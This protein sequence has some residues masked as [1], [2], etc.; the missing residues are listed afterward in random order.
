[1]ALE[2]IYIMYMNYWRHGLPAGTEP[3][4]HAGGYGTVRAQLQR[5]RSR[6]APGESSLAVVVRR[7]LLMLALLSPLAAAESGGADVVPLEPVVV[8]SSRSL[9]PV[10]EVV[11]MVTVLDHTDID[12]R[13]ATSADGLWRYTPGIQVESAGARFPARSLRIRGVGGNRV[14]MEVDGIPTQQSLAVGSFGYAARNGAE[15]DFIRRIEVLRGPASSLY[16]S[17]AIGGVVAVST[18]DPA[19]FP[20]LPGDSGGLLKGAYSGDRDSLGASAIGA[21]QGESTGWLLAGSSRRG[22]EADLSADPP[23][24]DRLDRDRAAILAKL[25][26]AD[27]ADRRLRLTLDADR[28]EAD[29]ALNSLVGQSRFANT[30]ALTGDDRETGV[31]LALDGH[32]DWGALRLHGAL[33]HR[34]TR[35]RQDTLDVRGAL[36]S[37]V[38]IEREFRFDTTTS[39]ARGRITRELETGRLRHRM[40]LGI[41]YSRRELEQSRDALQTDLASGDSSNIV[42][43]EK[44]PLRDFPVTVIHESGIFLQDEID[45]MPGS[46][47]VIPSVRFDRSRITV[48]DDA[49]WRA[50]NPDAMLAE[51]TVSDTS[52]RLGVLWRPS[53]AFQAWGQ[54]ATGFRAPPAEDLNIGLDIPLFGVR[55]LPNPAL[56]SETSVGWE[57]GVRGNVRGAWYSVAGFWTDYDDFIVSLV[58]LGPDPESGTLLFQSQNLER[59]RI[60]GSELEAGMPLGLLSGRLK[61]F[62]AGFSG[63]WAE[64]ENRGQGREFNEA[65][66]LSAALHLDWL[67]EA[68]V[69]ELRLSGTFSRG[70]SGGE[71][72]GM[73]LF[74]VPGYGVI[75]LA[76]A[77]HVNPRLTLRAGLFNLSDK[78]WWRAS[79]VPQ[80]PADD[81]LI[82][83]F[84]APGRSASVSFN[85]G[86]GP[87][88][89]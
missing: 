25:V 14:A 16:G 36:G 87:G 39:G 55:A 1:M 27:D 47:T 67:S 70:R 77:W 78:T 19:D 57:L 13:M 79:D 66:A 28:E 51:Q 32:T 11:G 10:S 89:G 9:R 69:L 7:A 44:F 30:T 48:R 65:D 40:M 20:L 35:T 3:A 41:E 49:L 85:L 61:G 80:L 38:E 15:L 83:S 56:D 43:G 76:A 34:N 73:P 4:A 58:P 75:D 21:W 84:S 50:A 5:P 12:S 18:F 71:V 23:S 22:H 26:L 37:P 53:S 2:M 74:R 24:P 60:Y 86:F 45:G 54:L 72:D 33:F 17:S 82:P 46:W 81:P 63:Y 59:V 52:P 29:S 64:G 42:L 88:P 8:V 6:A 31:G 62:A 68:G